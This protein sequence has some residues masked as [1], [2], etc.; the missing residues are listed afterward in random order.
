MYI[1]VA[2]ASMKEI[3]TEQYRRTCE[4]TIYLQR[5]LKISREAAFRKRLNIVNYPA[6]IFMCK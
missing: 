5:I 2:A 1:T 3:K 6:A 4:V